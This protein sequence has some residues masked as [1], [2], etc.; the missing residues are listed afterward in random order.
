MSEFVVNWKGA[1]C[2][3]YSS[4]LFME[5]GVKKFNLSLLDNLW[6]FPNKVL[7]NKLAC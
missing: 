7:F 3:Q 2:V 6:F 1:P 4:Y 5:F